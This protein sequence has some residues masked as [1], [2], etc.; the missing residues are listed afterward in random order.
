MTH[1][2][3][4]CNSFPSFSPPLSLTSGRSSAISMNSQ[5]WILS[6][7]LFGTGELPVS[8]YM[9]FS[10]STSDDEWLPRR[11][12]TFVVMAGMFCSSLDV[13][14]L[15]C[16]DDSEILVHVLLTR[17]CPAS[18]IVDGIDPKIFAPMSI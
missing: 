7:I 8:A 14:S 5:S 10:G 3:F 13:E 16:T 11:Y 4:R 15:P 9:P 1:F 18:D 12:H 17:G 2:G 6:A